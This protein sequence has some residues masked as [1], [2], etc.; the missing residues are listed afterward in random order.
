M[1]RP[2]LLFAALAIGPWLTLGCD[3]LLGYNDL[4]PRGPDDGGVAAS[5]PDATTS[6]A[7][8]PDSGSGAQEASASLSDATTHE[9]G[10]PDAA[11]DARPD[12]SSDA[13]AGADAPF[14][15]TTPADSSTAAIGDS[16]AFVRMD[17]SEDA[18]VCDLSLGATPCAAIPPFTGQQIIDGNDSDFCGVPAINYPYTSGLVVSGAAGPFELDAGSD[19]TAIIRVGWS[20]DALHVFVH[21]VDSDWAPPPAGGCIGTCSQV[22]VYVAATSM[23]SGA[24]DGDNDGGAIQILLSAPPTVAQAFYNSGPGKQMP[25]SIDPSHYIGVVTPDGYSIEL[26]YPW[27]LVHP[28]PIAS[29]LGVGLDFAFDVEDGADASGRQ[30][31]SIFGYTPLPPDAGVSPACGTFFPEPWCDDR[32]WCTP[33]LE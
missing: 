2:L 14:D 15:A 25:I 30:W 3:T 27:P 16:G 10:A 20:T 19:D 9:T 33:T 8:N 1:R 12:A 31:Q 24:Y 4:S 6:A 17:A 11:A 18:N 21:V 32:T 22:E 29:G 26:E 5:R 7:T 13:T 28:A 23:L